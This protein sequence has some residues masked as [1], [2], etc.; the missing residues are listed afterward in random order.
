ME[1]RVVMS[2][3]RVFLIVDHAIIRKYTEGTSLDRECHPGMRQFLRDIRSVVNSDLAVETVIIL[4]S[5]GFTTALHRSRRKNY[6]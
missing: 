6:R 1:S 2:A 5:V 3:F 4:K